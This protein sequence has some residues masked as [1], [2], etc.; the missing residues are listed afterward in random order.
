[1]DEAFR[2]L[3]LARLIALRCEVGRW[4]RTVDDRQVA[5]WLMQAEIALDAAERVATRAP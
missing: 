5:G 4:A 2:G 3:L 1:M